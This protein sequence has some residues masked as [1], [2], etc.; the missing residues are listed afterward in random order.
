MSRNQTIL[1]IDDESSVRLSMKAMLQADFEVL[2]FEKGPEAVRF[3]T[4]RQGVV[5]AAFV[6]YTMP[7]MSGNRVCAALRALDNTISLI[8]FSG[9]EEAQFE[10]PLFAK[11]VK[12]NLSVDQVS[13]IALSAVSKTEELRDSN[14]GGRPEVR[15]LQDN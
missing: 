15:S 11:L 13:K 10:G 6:D 3:V 5:S 9:N 1:V 8:G 7:E 12:K 4:E 2:T 14:R